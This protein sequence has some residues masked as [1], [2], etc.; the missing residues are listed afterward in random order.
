MSTDRVPDP[1][2][3]PAPVVVSIHVA[4]ARRLPM[5]AV[6]SVEVEAGKG[7][8]GD[9]YHGSRRRHVTVQSLEE[10]AEA[11][12]RAGPGEGPGIDPAR[13]RR[14]LTLSAGRLPRTPGHRFRIGPIEL[15]VVRDAAP[16][17][18]LDDAIGRAA[19]LALA[20]RA[21]VVCRVLSDGVLRVGDAALLEVE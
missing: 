19:R 11:T 9:R 6:G 1:S 5:R 16:C 12:A 8:I 18:L 14:N 20:R 7:L 10:L 15:E 17:K 21:G 13:T 3:A 2:G 4:K